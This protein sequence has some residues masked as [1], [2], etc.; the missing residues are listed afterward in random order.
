MLINEDIDVKIVSNTVKYFNEIGYECKVGDAIKVKTLDLQKNSNKLIRYKCDKCGEI[1]TIHYCDYNRSHKEEND[2]CEKCKYEKTKK[3]N[4][5]RYGCENVMGSEEIRKRLE[6]TN[7]KKYG[8]P[9]AMQNKSVREKAKKTNIDRYGVDN[10]A[11]LESSKIK[12]YETDMKKYGV[13]HHLSSKSV[14]D[15]RVKTNIERYG[16]PFVLMSNDIIA[17]GRKTL[18]KNGTCPTSKQQLHIC[19]L[20]GGILNYPVDRT[21]LDIFFKDYG[22]YCEYDGGGHRYMVLSG[23]M[24]EEEF[25]KR[26]IRRS[27]YLKSIGLKEFRIISRKDTMPSDEI[28]LS[29]KDFAFHKLLDEGYNWIRFDIDNSTVEYS[30]TKEKYEFK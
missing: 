9:H 23:R 4:V 3:T 14:I 13:K 24:T 7:V 21:N 15:K 22:I 30:G 12:T 27:N 11:K 25:D 1:K 28:L 29:M 19:G 2:Y 26:E 18:Y 20:Y 17:K 8:V 10:P 16:V 5:E 6:E